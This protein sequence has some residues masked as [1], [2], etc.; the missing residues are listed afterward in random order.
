MEPKTYSLVFLASLYALTTF[1][2]GFLCA[3]NFSWQWSGIVFG[4]CQIAFGG[5]YGY[6][7]FRKAQTKEDQI[8][9]GVI[10]LACAIGGL[11]SC[12]IPMNPFNEYSFFSRFLVTIFV[13]GTYYIMACLYYY[14]PIQKLGNGTI[15]TLGMNDMKQTLFYMLTSIPS[16]VVL[17]IALCINYGSSSTFWP[18]VLR[19]FI[20]AILSLAAGAGVAYFLNS[21]K[22]KSGYET[23]SI[24][25]HEQLNE[26]K[27]DEPLNP[28]FVDPIN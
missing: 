24:Q 19:A 13:A 3:F 22:S 17:S 23:T 7:F 18:I 25:D 5:Y 28:E 15:P 9:D 1:V 8:Y 2:V 21:K 14:I 16:L 4:L 26:Q 6:L 27:V 10:C 11:I 20:S 12:I